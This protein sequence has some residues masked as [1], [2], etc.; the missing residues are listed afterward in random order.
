MRKA[1]KPFSK[2]VYH[3]IALVHKKIPLLLHSGP[4]FEGFIIISHLT[5]ICM[6]QIYGNT[7]HFSMYL[8]TIEILLKSVQD[9]KPFLSFFFFKLEE[10][11]FSFSY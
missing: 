6:S 9:F 3:I 2:V 11:S 4:H 8:L 10:R 5:F 1:A 7:E